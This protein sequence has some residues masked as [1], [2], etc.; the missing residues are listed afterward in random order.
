MAERPGDPR[1]DG[2]RS[3]VSEV[4]SYRRRL[5]RLVGERTAELR[6]ANEMLRREAAELAGAEHR[7][8]LL[9]TALEAVRQG[10]AITDA[11]LDGPGPKLL[12]VY[13]IVNA[14]MFCFL[15]GAMI[16]V[17]ATAVGIPFNIAILKMPPV[18]V[19]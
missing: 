13:N 5:E 6:A 7:Q 9:A 11:S 2:S 1:S 4:L 3:D 17:A 14:L 18:S 16:S 15:A 10:V 12:F 8:R 19:R